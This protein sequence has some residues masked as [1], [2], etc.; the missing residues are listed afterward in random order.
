MP[1]RSNAEVCQ[2]AS[3][4]DP[5][6]LPFDKQIKFTE[7]S[8]KTVDVLEVGKGMWENASSGP[9]EFQIYG[10]DPE[11]RAAACLVVMKEKDKDVILGRASSLIRTARSLKPSIWWFAAG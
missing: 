9:T 4:H 6:G 2:C 1:G 5:A 11:A 8:D 3:K 10:A 7:N